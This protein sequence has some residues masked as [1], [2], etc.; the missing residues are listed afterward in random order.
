MGSI[1]G[2]RGLGTFGR[3]EFDDDDDGDDDDDNA[4]LQSTECLKCFR[5]GNR[6]D[7][8]ISVSLVL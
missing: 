1:G 6:A 2:W 5:A 3:S 4:E 8:T 7:K